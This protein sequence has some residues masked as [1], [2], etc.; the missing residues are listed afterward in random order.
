MK[1]FVKYLCLSAVVCSL[2]ISMGARKKAITATPASSVKTT[3]GGGAVSLDSM[4][5]ITG[6]EN[7][8]DNGVV[9]K[10]TSVAGKTGNA[11]QTAYSMGAG[12]WFGI[13]KEIPVDLSKYAGIRFAFRGEGSKNTL[14]IKLEDSDGSNFGK[15][16]SG[17]SD[18]GAWTVIEVPFSDLKYFWGG[19]QTLDL[20]KIRLH[21]A[22]SKKEGD[23]GGTGKI[24]IDNI[25][26]YGTGS[27]A[28]LQS[29]AKQP[30]KPE[31][32]AAPSAAMAGDV[33]EA[34]KGW[35][36]YADATVV[37]KLAPVA[38][39]KG[40]AIAIDYD[41]GSGA[42]FGI[43]KEIPKDISKYR[44]I[45]FSFKGEGS[46]NSIELKIEDK[47]GS[48]YGK[49]LAQKSNTAAWTTVELLFSDLTYF[50][51]GNQTL[52]LVNNPKLHFA[53]SKKGDEDSGGKGKLLIE[54]IELIK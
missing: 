42:W 46:Q 19:D 49:L 1:S 6:W 16:M 43:W 11:A 36:N 13:W 20:K 38:G 32:A 27:A 52:D 54:Q 24:M 41:M 31:I 18:N 35:E 15:E 48:N 5:S 17:K 47:D 21:F 25:E 9:L 28:S 22:V 10:V 23:A 50:W 53:V 14:E 37:V 3:A 30:E 29:D 40:S 4:D 12:A 44:G 8:A 2:F 39:R 7:Y 51:G 34:S 45:K 33:V 26:A